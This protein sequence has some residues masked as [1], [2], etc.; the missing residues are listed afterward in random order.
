MQECSLLSHTN[1]PP[2]PGFCRLVRAPLL[3]MYLLGVFTYAIWTHPSRHLGSAKS[4]AVLGEGQC[5]TSAYDLHL[6]STTTKQ[7]LIPKNLAPSSL[8]QAQTT[9]SQI[10]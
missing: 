10:E 5:G 4:S 1:P 8:N 6:F 3:N 7:P 9:P 2:P